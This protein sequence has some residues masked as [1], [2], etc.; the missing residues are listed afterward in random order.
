MKYLSYIVLPLALYC[1]PK[2]ASANSYLEMI[3]QK[4]QDTTE[5]Q[6]T[7]SYFNGIADTPKET[8]LLWYDSRITT[9]APVVFSEYPK[10]Q[11]WKQA[12][13]RENELQFDSHKF[14]QNLI[15][16]AEGGLAAWG[17]YQIYKYH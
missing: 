2:T 3:T 15:Y 4:P 9:H 5:Q 7:D 14:I 1:F 6:E 11:A 16:G 12:K 8:P 10:Y 13:A 17:I